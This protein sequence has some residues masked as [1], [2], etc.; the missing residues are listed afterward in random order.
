[1]STTLAKAY[2]R[3]NDVDLNRDDPAWGDKQHAMSFLNE[4]S[5]DLLVEEDTALR[6]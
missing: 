2:A 6:D 1:M 3:G 4:L 5:S